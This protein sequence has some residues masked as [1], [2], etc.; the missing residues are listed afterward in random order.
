VTDPLLAGVPGYSVPG[1]GI[2]AGARLAGEA[3]FERTRREANKRDMAY[4]SLIE[5][6][7]A[8]TVDR[9]SVR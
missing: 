4:Q 9:H 1:D 7:P 5:T 3:L 8:E 2:G 6:W